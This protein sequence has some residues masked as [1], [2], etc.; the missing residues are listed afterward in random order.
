MPR[1]LRWIGRIT[2]IVILTFIALSATTPSARPTAT[3]AIGL[4]FFP[5][6]VGIGLL[7]AWWRERAGAVVATLGLVAFYAW[8]LMSGA[9]FARGPW[10]VVCWSPTVFFAASWYLRGNERGL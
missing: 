1:V 4:V 9:H 10:F 6:M 7:L 2:S 8:S 5:G 3:Q